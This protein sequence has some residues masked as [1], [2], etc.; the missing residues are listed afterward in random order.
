MGLGWVA[1][2]MEGWKKKMGRRLSND[3]PCCG[4]SW[5]LLGKKGS[6]WA[7]PPPPQDT[8]GS[9]WALPG[10]IYKLE[11]KSGSSPCRSPTPR[12]G[13]GDLGPLKCVCIWQW[14][15]FGVLCSSSAKLRIGSDLFLRVIDSWA[16][17]LMVP[18]TPAPLLVWTFFLCA[19]G[20]RQTHVWRFNPVLLIPRSY[21]VVWILEAV[22]PFSSNNIV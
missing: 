16:F 14:L 2:T 19:G 17:V 10:N 22:S 4:F 21:S 7:P 1:W 5:I 13:N 18:L 3:R 15:F 20:P 9:L 6:E 8:A 12:F 11:D